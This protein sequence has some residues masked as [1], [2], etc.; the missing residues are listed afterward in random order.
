ME[1]TEGEVVNRTVRL[2]ADQWLRLQELARR[3]KR[4]ATKQLE[5]ILEAAL[6]EVQ[7]AA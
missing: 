3:Q 2:R 1:D 6:D 7:Q 4:S 5:L